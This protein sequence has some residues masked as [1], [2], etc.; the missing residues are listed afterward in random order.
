MAEDG[1]LT[2]SEVAVELRCSKA[3]VYNVVNGKVRGVSG[4]PVIAMGRRKLI[5]RSA[6]ERWK[7]ENERELR[8]AI[9]TPSPIVDAVRRA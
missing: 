3:H 8:N 4:L 7:R 9:L 2:V 5:R 6:L 1:V